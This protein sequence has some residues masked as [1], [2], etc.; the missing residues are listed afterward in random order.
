MTEGDSSKTFYSYF[1]GRI[2]LQWA[3]NI[4]FAV[5][6]GT[7]MRMAK[8]YN[9]D[10]SRVAMFNQVAITCALLIPGLAL[11]DGAKNAAG[12]LT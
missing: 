4:V 9:S 10:Y 3:M 1:A 6:D 11:N 2:A 8:Q 7:T 12:R 5:M